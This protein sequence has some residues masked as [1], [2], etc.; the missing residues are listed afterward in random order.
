VAVVGVVAA[1]RERTNKE[2]GTRFGFLT[3]EDLTG[4][5]EVVC[6]AS[7]TA[8]HNR[9]PQ[10]GWAD[11]ENLVKSDEP[12]L[13]HGEVRINDRDAE[14]PRAEITASDVEAL[15]AVRTQKTSEIALRIDVDKL[16]AERAA[17][18]KTLLARFPGGCAVT[19]R[20]VI[21]AQSETTLGV[22]SKVQ[23]ADELLESARRLGFE[24][25]L[26]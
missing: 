10:R 11:W 25:E 1:V 19:V 22:A 9:P 15:S 16:T 24:V 20:A 13:V 2:K 5:V 26:R 8:S 23:P 14:N 21:P 12:I 18:L 7:R 6:W 17:D 3:L 4:T